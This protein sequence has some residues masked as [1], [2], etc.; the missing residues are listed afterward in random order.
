MKCSYI[1]ASFWKFLKIS[2]SSGIG[3]GVIMER[4][5]YQCK[6]LYIGGHYTDKSVGLNY[7]N[8]VYGTEVL[9]AM[10]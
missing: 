6:W 5:P 7:E 1:L 3:T 8:A 9:L 4:L 10:G 2:P